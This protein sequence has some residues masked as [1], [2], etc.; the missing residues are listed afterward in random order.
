VVA[1]WRLRFET[2]A[3]I[4]AARAL[5]LEEALTAAVPAIDPDFAVVIHLILLLST[6]P[7]EINHIKVVTHH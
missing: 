5:V 4:L 3:A 7:N 1:G 6:N 2:A